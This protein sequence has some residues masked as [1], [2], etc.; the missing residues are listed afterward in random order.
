LDQNFIDYKNQNILLYNKIHE[1]AKGQREA[2][3]KINHKLSLG[4]E[5]EDSELKDK[6]HYNNKDQLKSDENPQELLPFMQID[7]MRIEPKTIFANE[8]TLV[9]WLHMGVLISMIGF[10]AWK[11]S[12]A[13]VNVFLI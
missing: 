10:L 1:S 9:K 12:N 4:Y 8:R 5:G 11:Y 2:W 3:D 13:L 7:K 6:K